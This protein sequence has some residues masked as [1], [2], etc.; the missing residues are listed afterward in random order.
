MAVETYYLDY[1]TDSTEQLWLNILDYIFTAIFTFETLI[2][3]IAMGVVFDKGTYLRYPENLLD[4]FIVI[5]SLVDNVLLNMHSNKS[6]NYL[7]I[8]RL[9]RTIRPL[10]LITHS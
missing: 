2:K 1:A 4:F 7:K 9:L 10:R 6:L 8:L 5:T 3:M